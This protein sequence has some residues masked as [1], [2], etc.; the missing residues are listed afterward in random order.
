MA[1]GVV[2]TTP[3]AGK[4]GRFPWRIERPVF[5]IAPPRSGSTFLFECLVQFRE[6]TAF[7]DREGTF[8]WRRVFPYEQ[9]PTMSDAI[10]P[11]EFGEWRRRQVKSLFYTRGLLKYPTEHGY[12]RLLRLIRQPGMRYLD[13]TISNA[14]RLDLIKDMFPDAVFVYLV[15]EPRANLA[16]MINGWSDERFRKPAQTRYVE[17]TGSALQYWAYAA[18]PGWRDTLGWRLPEVCAWSWK[19]HAEAILRFRQTEG[20]GPLIRYEDV[21]QDP[22]RVISGLAHELDLELTPHIVDYLARPPLSRTT[23]TAPGSAPL[24]TE[25]AAQVEAVMPVIAGT[26]ARFGY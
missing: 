3:S 25:V 10:T 1:R 24:R 4:F 19:Q 13:K 14:F 21:A 2:S 7:T 5:V 6:L 26:A 12:D 9:R 17:E 18:P 11:E 8:I 22:L 20:S 16:S 15:R 23:L